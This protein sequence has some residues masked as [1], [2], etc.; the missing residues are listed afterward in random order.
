V[1]LELFESYSWGTKEVRNVSGEEM[2]ME[3]AK[4]SEDE[5]TQ[6]EKAKEE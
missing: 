4:E 5:Q 6:R 1:S 2:K 3:K